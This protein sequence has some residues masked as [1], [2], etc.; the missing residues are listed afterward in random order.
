MPTKVSVILL[1]CL[2]IGSAQAEDPVYFPDANL[3]AIVE[4]ALWISD[5]TPSDMLSPD[6]LDTPR[7]TYPV[8]R[9]D[10]SDRAGVRIE[11]SDAQSSIALHQ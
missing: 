11:P 3:K 8:Q 2:L 5:P 4:E 6:E 1:F 7:G 9:R 10:R